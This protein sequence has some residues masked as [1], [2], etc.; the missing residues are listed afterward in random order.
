VPQRPGYASAVTRRVVVAAVIVTV[1]AGAAPAPGQTP[2]EPPPLTLASLGIKGYLIF[3]NFSHFHEAPQD[4][5]HFREEGILQLEWARKL[6]PWGDAKLVGEAR[7]DDD[8]FAQGVNFQIPEATQHRSILNLKEAVLTLKENPVE[9]SFGKQIFAWGTADFYNPTDNLNPSDFL[10]PIDPEKLAVYSVA[11]RLTAGPSS[12]VFV[13]VPVF[14]PSRSP[15]GL[16]RWTPVPE[17]PVIVD[18]RELPSRDV[19]NMQYA[20]R[21]RT[22]VAGWDVSLSYFDGFENNPL[23]RRVP[24]PFL[25]RFVPVFP[26]IK[27]GRTS[28][29]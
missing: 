18:D 29:L 9:V 13:I 7:G 1:L 14:T 23:I 12:L 15:F 28:D 17:S 10:D 2:S 21:A 6:A 11:S 4:N 3:K 26:R 19:G 20:A 16:S 27:A 8:G 5:R 25:P 24:H 22:T